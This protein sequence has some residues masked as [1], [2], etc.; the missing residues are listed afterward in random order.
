MAPCIVT[1]GAV[2]LSGLDHIRE[3]MGPNGLRGRRFNTTAN[4][5]TAG[6]EPY[7]YS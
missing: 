5:L 7:K 6:V 4:E 2:G 1:E 3:S